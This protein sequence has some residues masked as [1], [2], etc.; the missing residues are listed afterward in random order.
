M[1]V[2]S[3]YRLPKRANSAGRRKARVAYEGR[4]LRTA[5]PSAR[6]LFPVLRER[7]LASRPVLEPSRTVVFEHVLPGGGSW[8]Q[9][10]TIPPVYGEPTFRNVIDE[11]G[12]HV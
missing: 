4:G 2:R 9:K 1:S 5:G 8:R 7:L 11:K 3:V 12:R 10:Q 6:E